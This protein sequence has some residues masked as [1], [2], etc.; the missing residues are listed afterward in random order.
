MRTC[1]TPWALQHCSRRIW[2]FQTETYEACDCGAMWRVC[3][4]GHV[5]GGLK[6]LDKRYSYYMIVFQ[7]INRKAKRQCSLASK[8]KK[9]SSK[10]GAKHSD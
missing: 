2:H 6:G 5:V 8:E 9:A 1:S 3:Y 4:L 10:A 7:P